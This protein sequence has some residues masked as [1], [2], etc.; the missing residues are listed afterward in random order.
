MIFR[1]TGL[2]GPSAFVWSF[3]IALVLTSALAIAQDAAPPGEKA[4]EDRGFFATIGRW[5]SQQSANVGATFNDARQKVEGLGQE[6]GAAAKS[7]VEGAKD[8]AGAVARIPNARSVSG[9]EKCQTAPNGAPDCIA[10]ANALCKAKG[11]DSGRSLDMTTAE[12]CPPKVWMSG[13]STGP[14]CHT[15]TFVSRAF[16]Q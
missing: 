13:R 14:E 6:A 16:C 9:H 15:E 2:A 1:R 5:F 3:S 11:F 12:I 8:A 7:T 10:A 4:N